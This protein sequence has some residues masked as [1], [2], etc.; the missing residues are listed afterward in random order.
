MADPRARRRWPRRAGLVAAPLVLAGV[1]AGIVLDAPGLRNAPQAGAGGAVQVSTAPVVRADLVNTTQV[2]GSLSY[3]GSYTLVNQEQ[4]TAFTQLPGPGA[5]I[6]RGQRLY[7]VDGTPVVLFY[8]ARPEWRALAPGVTPGPD[9]AQLDANLIALGYGAGLTV[10]TYYTDATAYAVELWQSARGLPVTGTV[11]L[12][13]VAYAPGPLRVTSVTPS[14]GSVPQPGGQV[15]TAT[16]PVPVVV[17]ALPV[18]QE[19]LVRSG[20]R[21]TVT[22]PDGVTTTPGV[23]SS[24]SQVATA[25][26][27]GPGGPP[28]G[29]SPAPSGG[30]G[31]GQDTVQMTVRLTNSPARPAAGNLDQAPVT[32]NIVTAQARGVLAVPINALVALAGGGY[33]VD[34][35]RGTGASAARHLAA[36]QTGLFSDTLVQ[37]TGGGLTVGMDVEVPSS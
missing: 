13:Q 4:G 27:G 16:S 36:V 30:A 5:L 6:R 8:G 26:S 31:G 3:Q 9:V 24:V 28:G 18:G 37:V 1:T 2:A 22:L 35:V 15:L 7:E 17:A 21:V 32:V 19:Y 33:A 23:V 11:P 10:S 29:A 34:V 25:A 20:D 12:G 14:L